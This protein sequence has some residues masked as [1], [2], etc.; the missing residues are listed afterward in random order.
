[1]AIELQSKRLSELAQNASR[2]FQFSDHE[3]VVFVNTGDVLNGEFL[4]KTYTSKVGLPGQAKKRIEK[5]DI[6]FSEIRPANKRF[7]F[8]D[9]E[10]ADYVVSTKFM[11]IQTKGEV[12]SKYL[13][14]VLTSDAFLKNI[15]EIAE[16]RSGT[17]PQ[18]TFDSISHL[19]IS[20]PTIND[21][22]RI[23]RLM[24]AV[25]R[26]SRLTGK[27]NQTLESIVQTIFKSWF[28]DFDPVKAKVEG[29]A[30]E[31]MDTKTAGMF[32]NKFEESEL[33]M[34]PDGWSVIELGSFLDVLESGKRPKGGVSKFKQGIPSI[35]AENI[36]GIGLY[37]YAKT[38]Y[39]PLEFFQTM[40]RGIIEVEDVLLYKDG[41]KPGVFRPRVSMFG[42][43]FPYKKSVINEH[44]FRLRSNV[45]GQYYL[46]FLIGSKQIMHDLAVRG[47]KA[48]I[49]GINQKE[50]RSLKF[51]KPTNDLIKHFNQL[52][53][54]IGEQILHA[55][56]QNQTLANIRDTLL[57]KLISGEVKIRMEETQ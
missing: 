26:M 5:G 8:V 17:F 35:G 53:L 21:Q 50:V 29:R 44:V 37:N 36:L 54:P 20:Y 49:P 24:D 16:S 46:Y 23:V 55:A 42:Y 3:D 27:I 57:P 13:F 47:G 18:I 10:C 39:I 14:Y 11:T 48:A 30:P 33:G 32:P 31:G 12:L 43:G 6:L 9:I 7:V 25:N 19:Q 51:I 2:S 28:V 22:E 15:Q 41:G 40:K 52:A 34:I 38:K 4:H 56:G 1:M 45:L